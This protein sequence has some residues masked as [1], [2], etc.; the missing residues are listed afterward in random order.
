MFHKIKK[1]YDHHAAHESENPHLHHAETKRG[2][3]PRS[4]RIKMQSPIRLV[5]VYCTEIK[6]K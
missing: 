4:I 3:C 2:K 1:N 5:G 6:L